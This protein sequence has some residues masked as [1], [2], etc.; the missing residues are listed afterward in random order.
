MVF[1]FNFPR[2]GPC[3]ET[4]T[5]FFVELYQPPV[6]CSR[7]CTLQGDLS[8]G[9]ENHAGLLEILLDY[10]SGFIKTLFGI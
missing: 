1:S 6:G 7:D 3:A 5:F 4:T 10:C 2:A 9:A 8:P